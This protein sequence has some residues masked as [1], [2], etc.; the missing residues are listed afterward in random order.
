MHEPGWTVYV[1]D[2]A[3]DHERAY[4]AML[5]IGDGL[6]GVAGAPVV[7]HPAGTS[8]VRAPGLFRGKGADTDLLPLPDCTQLELSHRP[9]MRVE[10][11][12]DMRTGLLEQRVDERGQELSVTSF[13]S[14]ARP[15]TFV[16]RASG[17]RALLRAGDPFRQLVSEDSRRPGSPPGRGR[18]PEP[19]PSL[20][21]SG[22]DSP[23]VARARAESGGAVAMARQRLGA[24]ELE[25]IAAYAVDPLEMPDELIAQT[26]LEDAVKTGFPRL[27]SEQCDAWRKRWES[28][29]IAIEGDPQLQL[30][31]RLAMFHLTCLIST[32]G[33]AAVPA[34]GTTSD[35][36]HGH[37][38]W[39]ADVFVLP[40]VAATNPGAARAM[41]RYRAR[42]LEAARENAARHGNAGARFPWESATTGEEA[43]PLTRIDHRGD[44]VDVLTGA[45]EEHVTADVAWAAD[46]YLAW[47][48]DQEFARG[49]G[50]D[51]LV[52]TARYWASRVER[53]SDGSCHIRGV[54][55]PDEY[56]ERVDDN[57]YTNVMA[58]WN[59][60]TAARHVA[61][62]GA[63]VPPV[64]VHNWLT[65]AEAI[66]DGYDA[67]SRLYE[68]FSGFHELDSLVATELAERPFSAPQVLG[69]R[70]TAGS[71]LVKQTDVLML[72]LNV[73][74][75]TVPGSLGPNLDFYEPR[76]THESSLSAGSSAEALARAGRPDDALRW[77]QESAFID[78]PQLRPVPRPGL[79]TAAM[80]N[81]WRAVV[82]GI[83]GVRPAENGL[84]IDPKLPSEWS[85]LDIRLVYRGASLRLRASP[86]RVTAQSSRPVR[87]AVG[88]RAPV[89]VGPGSKD[90]ATG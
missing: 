79:H 27:V 13:C 22:V 29:D 19:S 64:E 25:R 15:G 28:C 33:E 43:T 3:A 51:L 55:G 69:Y 58:R 73:P 34:R 32:T 72:H 35:T 83:M 6:L 71:Q 86:D 45:L 12:L 40:F 65:I 18:G 37:V 44:R 59:L 17:D 47:T 57:A 49:D 53:D 41:L 75:E 85:E 76:T 60:R 11:T 10:R 52:E 88:A 84:R 67:K 66:V 50:S 62:Y 63:P 9:G 48:G 46:T 81:T 38:F 24:G 23:N 4:S 82:L 68:Q 56:H 1:A 80:G 31:L 26:S 39:D 36:Y 87:L 14:L 21:T 16:L 30:A 70:R 20:T 78:M 8:R 90:I 89:T 2:V 5:E 7:Q 54:I 61:R 77:L 74:E 42:R